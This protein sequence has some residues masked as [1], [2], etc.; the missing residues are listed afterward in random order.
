M[1][2]R[3]STDPAWLLDTLQGILANNGHS[4]HNISYLKVTPALSS[5]PPVPQVDIEA[6][7]LASLPQWLDTGVL[8][9]VHQLGQLYT[10]M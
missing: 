3:E 8:D 1:G 2:A 4:Q 6:E 7:E 10:T 5:C 9:R